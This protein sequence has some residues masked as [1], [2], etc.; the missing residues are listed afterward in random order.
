MEPTMS[1]LFSGLPIAA[2]TREQAKE[3]ERLRGLLKNAQEAIA[4]DFLKGHAKSCFT[5]NCKDLAAIVECDCGYQQRW[6]VF[7]ALSAK[8]DK[9][10]EK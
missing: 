5:E 3:I 7:D 10:L 2:P 1:E 9:E 6:D 8:L 4:E